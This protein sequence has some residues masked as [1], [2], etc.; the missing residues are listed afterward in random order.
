[1]RV[2]YLILLCLILFQI[3]AYSYGLTGTEI[4]EKTIESSGGESWKRPK[5]LQLSGNA[6]LFW[7]GEEHKLNGYKLWRVFPESNDNA[8]Q[9]NGK[10]RFDAMQDKKV[11]FRIAF[12]GKN[13]FQ[14]LG[15]VAEK[16]KETLR[17]GNNFGFSI[18][19]FALDK[20]FKVLRLP[21]DR[22]DGFPCYFVK[23]IDPKK[24]E[25]IFGIDKKK[26]HIRYA[27]FATPL[28]FHER[29]YD[30]FKWHKKPKFIQ[31]G[32]LRIF[33]E[34]V[35]TAHVFWTKFKVNEPIS[36]EVFVMKS[37]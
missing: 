5:T 28:G 15:E 35:K 31:P 8:R 6:T 11:F 18:F 33:N 20:G 24:K 27:G 14:E 16:N 36:D 21:D 32:S 7:N 2:V 17:W 37:K 3:S 12:D 10:V 25:T 13:T 22:V 9:A 19:R 1:M 29:I 23:I 4:V 34:G 26:F 30:D